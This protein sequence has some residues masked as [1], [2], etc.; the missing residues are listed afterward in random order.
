MPNSEINNQIKS[1][2]IVPG[3]NIF[4]DAEENFLKDEK[5]F[6]ALKEAVSETGSII[7]YS[8][9]SLYQ[10]YRNNGWAILAGKEYS[11]SNIFSLA[12]E[13]STKKTNTINKVE[14]KLI[15]TAFENRFWGDDA[16]IRFGK[17]KETPVRFINLKLFTDY[18]ADWIF[19]NR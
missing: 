14:Y 5:I 8:E 15:G 17:L 7:F 11:E 2:N 13:L 19:K 18:A 1:L 10:L 16:V 9:M 3:M 4:L 12:E 6:A